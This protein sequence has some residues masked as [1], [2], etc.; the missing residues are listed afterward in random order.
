M[1]T[2]E[3]SEIDQAHRTWKKIPFRGKTEHGPGWPGRLERTLWNTQRDKTDRWHR[4]EGRPRDGWTQSDNQT[5]GEMRENMITATSTQKRGTGSSRWEQPETRTQPFQDPT[6]TNKA[7]Y[8]VQQ[9][10]YAEDCGFESVDAVKLFDEVNC[11][12]K[13]LYNG[14]M[15]PSK[16]LISQQEKNTATHKLN[17]N[18]MISLMSCGPTHKHS[19]TV[20]LSCYLFCSVSRPGNRLEYRKI[21]PGWPGI[22]HGQFIKTIFFHLTSSVCVCEHV[23]ACV[24]VCWW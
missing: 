15:P 16:V 1:I 6:M 11:R 5:E 19:H 13:L 14:K 4:E 12:H 8:S 18:E 7:S 24:C 21:W 22:K 20:S 2:S 10:T 23:C 9:E 3:G 17:Q